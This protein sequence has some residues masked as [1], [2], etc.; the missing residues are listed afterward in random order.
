MSHLRSEQSHMHLLIEIY[1]YIHVAR[2][3]ELYF[4]RTC[5]A[6][7]KEI[8]EILK[9]KQPPQQAHCEYVN[10]QRLQ[11]CSTINQP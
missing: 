4:V 11:V 5:T 9:L 3:W 1:V 10:I 8:R 6:N 7:K 2:K